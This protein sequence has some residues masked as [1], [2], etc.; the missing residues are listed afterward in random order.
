MKFE[1]WAHSI[2]AKCALKYIPSCTCH[3]LEELEAS[4]AIEGGLRVQH[5]GLALL[6]LD[7]LHLSI[8]LQNAGKYLIL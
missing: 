7:S 6:A 2:H 1:R 5:F 3:L 8:S 4:C